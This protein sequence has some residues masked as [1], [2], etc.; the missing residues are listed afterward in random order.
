MEKGERKKKNF[1]RELLLERSSIS[2]L[3]LSLSVLLYLSTFGM[4]GM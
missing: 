1:Q 2:A 4:I 3:Y